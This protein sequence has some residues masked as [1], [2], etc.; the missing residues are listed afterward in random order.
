MP[1]WSTV[2]ILAFSTL[3][4]ACDLGDVKFDSQG[5]DS[6]DSNDTGSSDDSGSSDVDCV[7]EDRFGAVVCSVYYTHE[8]VSGAFTIGWLDPDNEIVELDFDEVRVR[9]GSDDWSEQ[10]I[11]VT[12][13]STTEA[14][15][16][17]IGLTIP[18]APRE[19]ADVEIDGEFWLSD[20]TSVDICDFESGFIM[21]VDGVE[22]NDSTCGFYFNVDW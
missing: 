5:T 20:G 4:A 9:E 15:N 10:P 12:E 21:H 11:T 16:T 2:P 17:V 18:G 8:Q 3:L 14:G 1:K 22:L 19:D 13:H 6:G 7:A